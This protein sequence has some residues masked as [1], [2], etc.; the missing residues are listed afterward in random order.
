VIGGPQNIGTLGATAAVVA[1]MDIA[2]KTG[3][4][5]IQMQVTFNVIPIAGDGLVITLV[6]N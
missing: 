4:V 1:A 3:P 2:N 5:T 6:G